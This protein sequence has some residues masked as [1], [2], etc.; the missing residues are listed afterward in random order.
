MTKFQMELIGGIQDV[1]M[2]TGITT[3][4]CIKQAIEMLERE[5]YNRKLVS[6]MFYNW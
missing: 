3:K 2:S 4:E 1:A 6:D 5:E